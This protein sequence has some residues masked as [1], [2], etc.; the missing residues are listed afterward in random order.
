[1]AN[2][3]SKAATRVERDT[4]VITLREESMNL[5]WRWKNSLF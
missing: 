1:M 5:R 2:S 4:T 3:A